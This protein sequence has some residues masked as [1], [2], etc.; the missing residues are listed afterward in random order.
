MTIGL[1]NTS[2]SSFWRACI[3]PVTCW[4]CWDLATDGVSLFLPFFLD[5][6]SW[7]PFNENDEIMLPQK[8]LFDIMLK[9]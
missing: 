9:N 8:A 5:T 3:I 1:K 7:N 4:N 2:E 6:I